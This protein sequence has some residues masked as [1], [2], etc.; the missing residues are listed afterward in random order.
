[1]QNSVYI[2]TYSTVQTVWP[3]ERARP[4]VRFTSSLMAPKS[5][6]DA[7]LD[8][9]EWVRSHGG[10]VSNLSYGSSGLVAS[11]DLAADD[12]VLQIPLRC[13]VTNSTVMSSAVGRAAAKA[14]SETTTT[15][16]TDDFALAIFLAADVASNYEKSFHAPF[17]ALLPQYGGTP[18]EDDPRALLPRTWTSGELKAFLGGSEATIAAAK[19]SRRSIKSDYDAVSARAEQSS[20]HDDV[21]WPSFEYFDWACAIVSSRA[22]CLELPDSGQPLDAL[23]PLADMLNHLRPRQT[24][25]KLVGDG[26]N[27]ER[28]DVA[29]NRGDDF[30]KGGLALEMR[31]RVAIGA[32]DAVHSTYGAKGSSHLLNTYGFALLYN[33]E[34]DGSSNDVR[35]LPLPERVED[36]TLAP[37]LVY[38][39]PTS[40]LLRIGPKSYA[41]PPLVAAVDAFRAAA[42]ASGTPSASAKPSQGTATARLAAKLHLE[43]AALHALANALASEIDAYAM[44]EADAVAA[45]RREEQTSIQ[46]HHRTAAN[47]NGDGTICIGDSD[48]STGQFCNTDQL[49]RCRRAA[50]AA[51]LI[52][53]ERTT[54]KFYLRIVARCL[55]VISNDDD[56]DSASRAHDV[57][58]KRRLRACNLRSEVASASC[59]P[60]P[61]A[62]SNT[63]DNQIARLKWHASACKAAPIALAYLQ[64]RMPEL[65]KVQ[66]SRRGTNGHDGSKRDRVKKDLGQT[67]RE[68]K[69]RRQN[70]NEDAEPQ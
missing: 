57:M 63:I 65:L 24:T 54:L 8:A 15:M 17:Y 12:V 66:E 22:F 1:M 20:S 69:R 64:I 27:D 19:E 10:I 68:Q 25:Y 44:S 35:P 3:R 40:A 9:V 62:D 18:E 37:S 21:Q 30:C 34:P 45:L 23:V 58:E 39:P 33:F 29:V 16:S 13:C 4:Y 32:R 53:S 38:R 6:A 61:P 28:S 50:V 26:R 55:K 36:A 2:G 7:W 43:A 49:R 41:F 52:I 51:A 5:R 70:N 59:E 14:A 47:K 48:A 67:K 60:L 11:A 46:R 42:V 56:D 31:T